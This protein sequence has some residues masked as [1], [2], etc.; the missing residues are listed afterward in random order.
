MKQLSK[1]RTNHQVIEYVRDNLIKQ[2]KQSRSS[3]N[4]NCKYRGGEDYDLKCAIGWLIDDKWY[5]AS[6][7]DKKITDLRVLSAVE[8]SVPHWKIDMELLQQFQHIH[9]HFEPNQW[10]WQFSRLMAWY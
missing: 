4:G 8:K 1:L 5:Q 6:F 2:G 7:E 9:D 10:E 3:Y